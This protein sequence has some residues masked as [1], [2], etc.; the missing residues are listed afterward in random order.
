MPHLHLRI[1]F[2]S[3]FE[4]YATG[5]VAPCLSPLL[6]PP[7]FVL[8][9]SY[10]WDI[11]QIFVKSESDY[12]GV[13]MSV[14]MFATPLT[15]SAAALS[16]IPCFNFNRCSTVRIRQGDLAVLFR[17]ALC[18]SCI[19]RM[20]PCTFLFIFFKRL[21]A[22]SLTDNLCVWGSACVCMHLVVDLFV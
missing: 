17:W 12:V 5:S 18:Y 14:G 19:M 11:M 16:W 20:S 21:F 1:Q 7:S 3:D 2:T 8:A 4:G 13:E 22:R 15:L 9:S 10:T 6:T